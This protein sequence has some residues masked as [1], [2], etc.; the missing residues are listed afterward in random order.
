MAKVDND[1][2]CLKY[3]N[4]W[5]TV[6]TPHQKSHGTRPLGY[7]Q[8]MLARGSGGLPGWLGTILIQ[9]WWVIALLRG[10]GQAG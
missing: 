7:Y 3:D 8:V 2:A 9:Y 1:E 4:N 10:H 5:S 6:G